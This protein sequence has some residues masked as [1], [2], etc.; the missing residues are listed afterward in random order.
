MGY[1]STVV[2]VRGEP[3]ALAI[4]TGRFERAVKEGGWPVIPDQAVAMA[5][6]E[7]Q[8][9]SDWQQRMFIADGPTSDTKDAPAD[10][11]L[12]KAIEILRRKINAVPVSQKPGN[13]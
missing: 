7:F 12:A 6:Q 1:V 5:D 4:P 11:Q 13:P 9:L 2:Q 10:P 3:L 8:A